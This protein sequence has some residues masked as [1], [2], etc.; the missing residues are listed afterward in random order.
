MGNKNETKNELSQ[1]KEEDQIAGGKLV[2]VQ[3]ANGNWINVRENYSEYSSEKD[4]ASGAGELENLLPSHHKMCHGSCCPGH[5]DKKPWKFGKMK[6]PMMLPQPS[7]S[8]N[9]PE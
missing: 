8:G 7:G 4:A 3:L 2:Q 1:I 6:F 5:H 9:P